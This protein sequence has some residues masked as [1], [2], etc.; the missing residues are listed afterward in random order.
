MSTAANTNDQLHTPASPLPA[1]V[2]DG[3]ARTKTP[4][5][6]VPAV[7]PSV[8]T[9]EA[10]VQKKRRPGRFVLMLAVPLILAAGGTYV[11]VTGGRYQETENA[12]LK[13]ARVTISSEISGR[14]VK[15]NVAENQHVRAG[16]ILFAVDPEL[17]RIALAQA[18]AD[19]ATARLKVEQLRSTYSQ[20]M[21]K[22][23]VM[24][25]DSEY[26]KAELDRQQ[27]LT[28]KGVGTQSAL[29]S[30]RRD[31]V[32][33]QDELAAASEAVTGALAGLGGDPSIPTDSHPLVLAALAARDKAAF[34]LTQTTVT[35]P[36][37][38]VISQAESFKTGQFVNAGTP[39]FSLV[40][41][42]D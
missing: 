7:S 16:D 38:G 17:Y 35:A 19:L 20:A 22:Q 4:P 29:D 2:A 31:L 26:Y 34:D 8:A 41:T 33:A 14:V 24:A 10:P 40:E 1:P 39:V 25:S 36:A 11:W 37:D 32:N 12:N 13:Q 15:A 9:T 23:K 21:S 6:P 30:A 5:A 27:T 3:T 18:E 28:Q 42:G